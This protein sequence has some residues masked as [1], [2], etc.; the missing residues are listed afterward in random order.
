M[1]N[2]NWFEIIECDIE[3]RDQEI[4]MIKVMLF[5]FSIVLWYKLFN[6]KECNLHEN[7]IKTKN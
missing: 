5:C 3:D 7:K 2:T 4:E 1:E 6:W